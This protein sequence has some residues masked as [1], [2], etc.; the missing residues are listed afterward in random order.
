MSFLGGL[1]LLNGP[2][3]RIIYFIKH[4]WFYGS[5]KYSKNIRKIFE[6][7]IRK[8]GENIVKNIQ[9]YLRNRV[10]LTGFLVQI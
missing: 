1:G 10:T 2:T 3:P 5:E 7:H 4:H 6:L 8:S 9:T